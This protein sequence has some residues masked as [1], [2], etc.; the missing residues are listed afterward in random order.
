MGEIM[1]CNNLNYVVENSYACLSN[2]RNFN[3]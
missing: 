2:N 3:F 1:E